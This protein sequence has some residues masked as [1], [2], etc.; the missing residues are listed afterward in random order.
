M[1][2]QWELLS[3]PLH[4]SMPRLVAS[5]LAKVLL[6]LWTSA[7]VLEPLL[8]TLAVV[9][10]TALQTEDA[11]RIHRVVAHRAGV[12]FC[13]VASIWGLQITSADWALAFSTVRGREA[14]NLLIGQIRAA[15]R[16]VERRV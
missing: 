12:R 5:H 10:V 8:Q 7:L 4:A 14:S 16:H 15:R 6:A 2:R 1:T 3:V 11:I 13:I 9:M